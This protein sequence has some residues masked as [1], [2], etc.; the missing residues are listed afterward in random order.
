[1]T[2]CVLIYIQMRRNLDREQKDA[3]FEYIMNFMIAALRDSSEWMIRER[4]I[5][6][7]CMLRLGIDF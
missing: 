7:V 6:V 2:M 3:R 4:L 1:M 5:K